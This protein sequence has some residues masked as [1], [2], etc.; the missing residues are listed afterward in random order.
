M[1]GNNFETRMEALEKLADQQSQI[2]RIAAAEFSD[3]CMF[4]QFQ[5]IPSAMIDRLENST[6]PNVDRALT[7]LLGTLM[8]SCK[9]AN[10]EAVRGANAKPILDVLSEMIDTTQAALGYNRDEVTANAAY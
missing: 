7:A 5:L 6:E 9:Y 10:E 4:N 3:A 2:A 1:I 8:L